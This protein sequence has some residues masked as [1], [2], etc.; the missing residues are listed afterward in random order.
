MKRIKFL[1][2]SIAIV[3]ALGSSFATRVKAPCEFMTQYRLYNGSYVL[4]GTY[5]LDYL[6][7]GTLDVCTWYK[8][9]PT[10]SW[11]PCR[12]GTYIPAEEL[13]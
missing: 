10:S 1:L 3:T 7:T 13:K 9:W 12:A 2:I 6:C 11:T 5:G 8:P 4:A